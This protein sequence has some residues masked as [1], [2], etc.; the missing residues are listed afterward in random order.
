MIRFSH[1]S[2]QNRKIIVIFV[3]KYPGT[4]KTHPQIGNVVMGLTDSRDQ[5]LAHRAEGMYCAAEIIR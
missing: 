5:E 3:N 4:A 2:I 1:Y